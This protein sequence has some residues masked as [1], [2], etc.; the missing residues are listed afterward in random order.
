MSDELVPKISMSSS[1]TYLITD[2]PG[3]S[4]ENISEESSLFFKLSINCFVT[5]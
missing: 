1:W 2:C 3:V 4:D 5:L